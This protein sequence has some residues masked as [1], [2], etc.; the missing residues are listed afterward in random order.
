MGYNWAVVGARAETAARV[1]TS[2]LRMVRMV[3]MV[4]MHGARLA[5][6]LRVG[7]HVAR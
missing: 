6:E 3:H 7:E 5:G 4:R 2:R 1:K